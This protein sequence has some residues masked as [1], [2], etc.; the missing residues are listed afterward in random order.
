MSKTLLSKKERRKRPTGFRTFT[1]SRLTL[2][3]TVLGK[4]TSP[5]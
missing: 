2:T 5:D 4:L 1:V 3:I